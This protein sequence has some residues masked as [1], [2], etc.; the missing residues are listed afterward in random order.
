[1]SKKLVK[2]ANERDKKSILKYTKVTEEECITQGEGQT[3]TSVLTSAER[4]I[5]LKDTTP[6]P[7]WK[8]SQGSPLNNSKNSKP[9]KFINMSK[10]PEENRSAMNQTPPQRSSRTQ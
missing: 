2:A 3:D 5:E 6:T 4:G 8:R 1:M 9:A 10:T 7:K